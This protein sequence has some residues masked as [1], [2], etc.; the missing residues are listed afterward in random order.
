MLSG[1]GRDGR[2]LDRVGVL[3]WVSVVLVSD[4]WAGQLFGAYIKNV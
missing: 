1:I 4:V 3:K 2:R